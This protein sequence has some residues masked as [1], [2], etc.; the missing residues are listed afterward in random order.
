MEKLTNQN[1]VRLRERIVIPHNDRTAIS[2]RHGWERFQKRAAKAGVHVPDVPNAR[3]WSAALTTKEGNPIA[4]EC[5]RWNDARAFARMVAGGAEVDVVQLT[6]V[7]RNEIGSRWQV[8]WAGSATDPTDPPH[9][10]ARRYGVDDWTPAREI[11]FQ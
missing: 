8:K 1:K 7:P 4:I 6:V 11:V 10:I 3:F 2:T 5:E 9:M